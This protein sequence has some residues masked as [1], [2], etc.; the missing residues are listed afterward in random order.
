MKALHVCQPQ[1]MPPLQLVV[2]FPGGLGL[3]ADGGRRAA[4]AGQRPAGPGQPALHPAVRILRSHRVLRRCVRLCH[5]HGPQ[6]HPSVRTLDLGVPR[7][8]TTLS[9]SNLKPVL[10]TAL[11]HGRYLKSSAYLFLRCVSI[12]PDSLVNAMYSFSNNTKSRYNF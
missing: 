3:H 10:A 2:L 6:L 11:C 8:A 5:E 12:Y 4:P 7:I 9:A 1:M